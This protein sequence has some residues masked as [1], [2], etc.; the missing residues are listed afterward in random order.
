MNIYK[1]FYIKHSLDHNTKTIKY[2]ATSQG[3]R[4]TSD[5]LEALKS[6]IDSRVELRIENAR[7][8]FKRVGVAF[9]DYSIMYHE[10]YEINN[11]VSNIA[12][13]SREAL[14]A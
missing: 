4:L 7:L 9:N 1:G 11:M 12:P 13:V 6:K 3:L 8:D 5:T 2:V 14:Y 10:T